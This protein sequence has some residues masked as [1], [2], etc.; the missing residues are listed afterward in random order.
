MRIANVT[1]EDALSGVAR[2]SLA[3]RVTSNE[4]LAPSDVVITGGRVL[5]RAATTSGIRTYTV[6][7]DVSDVAGNQ[8]TAVG[9][10]TVRSN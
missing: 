7:A 3:V 10:C 8:A 4:P 1:A 6:S 9:T 2:G 5:V